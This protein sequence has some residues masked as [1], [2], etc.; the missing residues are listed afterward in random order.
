VAGISIDEFTVIGKDFVPDTAEDLLYKYKADIIRSLR[1]NLIDHD[2]DQPGKL[3]QS[4]N[5]NIEVSVKELVFELSMEDYWKFV[6]AG[7]DGTQT[8]H[9]SP[10]K[11]KN[12]DKIIPIDAMLSFIRVRGL[13]GRTS[14][15]KAK[16]VRSTKNRTIKKALKQINKQQALKSLAFAMSKSV[17]R[18]GIKPTHFFTDVIN[19]DLKAKMTKDLTEAFKH[20][21]EIAFKIK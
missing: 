1:E 9:G 20:D 15:K 16:Q 7:V 2:K 8:K 12:N 19:D 5:V 18:K 10:Y 11:Y 6:D 3:I 14:V 21:I 17:K 4:I 13:T